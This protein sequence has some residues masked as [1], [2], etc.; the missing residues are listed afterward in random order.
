MWHLKHA[1]KGWFYKA[2]CNVFS[3]WDCPLHNCHKSGKCRGVFFFF[4]VR[5]KLGYLVCGLG[6]FKFL[7]QKSW[8]FYCKFAEGFDNNCWCWWC[9][10]LI[11]TISGREEVYKTCWL[12][13]MLNESMDH[14]NGITST[15]MRNVI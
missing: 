3:E 10:I 4:K 11:L 15:T 13:A 12:R 5:A 1:M 14:E 7:L 8:G 9:S 6:N 2:V